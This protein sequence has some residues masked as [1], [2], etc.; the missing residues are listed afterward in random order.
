MA[1][2]FQEFRSKFVFIY[3][4]P[5]ANYISHLS[6]LS[7]FDDPNYAFLSSTDYEVFRYTVLS[8]FLRQELENI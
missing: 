4:K 2:F 8:G 5:N 6:Q 3:F 7:R 1:R